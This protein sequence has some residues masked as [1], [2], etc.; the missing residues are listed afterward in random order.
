MATHQEITE[1]LRDFVANYQA[2]GQDKTIYQG[3][4]RLIQI[5]P[6]DIESAHT[7]ALGNGLLSFREGP[8]AHPDLTLLAD[9]DVFVAMFAGDITPLELYHQG[10]LRLL[11]SEDDIIALDSIFLVTSW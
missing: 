1:S 9:S 3:P 10:K 6:T 5:L 4:N 7:L 8:E 2:K 11:G